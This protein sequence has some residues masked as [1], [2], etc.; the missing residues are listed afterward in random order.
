MKKLYTA[1]H[2]LYEE[3][4]VNQAKQKEGIYQLFTVLD[5]SEDMA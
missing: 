4:Y 1:N 2:K 5:F 3:Y